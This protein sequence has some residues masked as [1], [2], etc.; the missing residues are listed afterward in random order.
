M[1]KN[2]IK[3]PRFPDVGMSPG[4][5]GQEISSSSLMVVNPNFKIIAWGIL[6]GILF[7]L[8]VLFILIK[9]I[10]KNNANKK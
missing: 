5:P 8:I 6:S 1:N 10:K 3:I 9:R 7:L 2:M 4:F